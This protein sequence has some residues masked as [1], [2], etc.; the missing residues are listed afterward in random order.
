MKAT[1][2]CVTAGVGDLD[3]REATAR[4]GGP[5]NPN[6]LWPVPVRGFDELLKR[7]SA[8][9]LPFTTQAQAIPHNNNN[10]D[11]QTFNQ[12]INTVLGTNRGQQTIKA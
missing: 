8:Q 6:R 3:W 5:N 7:K 11:V 12:S 2:T 10:D 1:A 4:A 9:V